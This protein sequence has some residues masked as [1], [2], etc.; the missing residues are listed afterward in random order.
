MDDP[1]AALFRAKYDSLRSTFEARLASLA[2]TIRLAIE[3]TQQDQ[4]LLQLNASE[5]T[6][7]FAPAHA[8]ALIKQYLATERDTFSRGLAVRLA[9]AE[10]EL[11][12]CSRRNE[13]LKSVVAVLKGEAARGERSRSEAIAVD[14]DIQELRREYQIAL[15]DSSAECRQLQTELSHAKRRSGVLKGERDEQAAQ[16][17]SL[18][19]ALADAGAKELEVTRLNDEL[20]EEKSGGVRLSSELAQAQQRLDALTSSHQ[21][22]KLDGR[23]PPPV[24]A[25]TQC[26]QKDLSQRDKRLQL[27]DANR[28]K[29]EA[30]FREAV[31]RMESLM[32]GEA[33]DSAAAI[34]NLRDK[35][36][37]AKE[38]LSTEVERLRG[39]NGHLTKGIAVAEARGSELELRLQA[40]L[41]SKE[42]DASAADAR[43]EA[44][45][46]TAEQARTRADTMSQSLAEAIRE[47]SGLMTETANAKVAAEV[48]EAKSRAA[49]VE[50]ARAAERETARAQAAANERAPSAINLP[51]PGWEVDNMLAEK[52]QEASTHISELR[53]VLRQEVRRREAAE[54]EVSEAQGYLKSSRQELGE[55]RHLA[56]KLEQM[57]RNRHEPWRCDDATL[58]TYEK[59]PRGFGRK[60]CNNNQ[61]ARDLEDE[62]HAR[63]V[64]GAVGEVE[65]EGG[66]GDLHEQERETGRSLPSGRGSKGRSEGG[67]KEEPGLPCARRRSVPQALSSWKGG[68]RL[69]LAALSGLRAELRCVNTQLGKAKAENEEFVRHCAERVAVRVER[70]ERAVRQAGR[71]QAEAQRQA[72]EAE[73]A[74]ATDKKSA[75]TL[76]RVV[77]G[78]SAILL[79]SLG[80]TMPTCLDGGEEGGERHQ[81]MLERGL[82]DLTAGITEALSKVKEGAKKA[83]PA[84]PQGDSVAMVDD[85][86]RR[87]TLDGMVW[88]E[89]SKDDFN[90][91][92]QLQK[93]EAESEL[94][95]LQA[96]LDDMTEKYSRAIADQETVDSGPLREE[97]ERA[98]QEL[99]R[100]ARAHSGVV[101]ALEATLAAEKSHCQDLRLKLERQTRE[102][103]V[104]LADVD[105]RLLQTQQELDEAQQALEQAQ[106]ALERESARR[107]R[108]DRKYSELEDRGLVSPRS[109]SPRSV[110]P[111]PVTPRPVT[112]RVWRPE[113]TTRKFSG[114]SERSQ[115]AQ[116]TLPRPS[117]VRLVLEEARA[118]LGQEES[119]D[120]LAATGVRARQETPADRQKSVLDSRGLT[121]EL[122]SSRRD[123]DGA[124]KSASPSVS[125]L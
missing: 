32:E 88:G 9:E 23:I 78:I 94:Q 107:A 48:L 84:Q 35:A 7:E 89:R 34:K 57:G 80:V 70:L 100:A 56:W 106:F 51:G 116:P 10:A 112:P 71:K 16:S 31:T 68:Q 38:R 61:A 87:S 102:H 73:A 97:R 6:R 17:R 13:E 33:K 86:H 53:T 83:L 49:E 36:L 117:S 20:R 60:S 40:A 37:L 114:E 103:Q 85:R 105:Q 11:L 104:A 110:S 69:F 124:D 45:R 24:C 113:A 50:M 115:L 79:D 5:N 93:I 22:L 46:A 54:A 59:E 18:Q 119:D 120:A 99:A 125:A 101:S 66:R 72:S 27:A 26:L 8:Q 76:R 62:L 82:E 47:Q 4:V 3:S 67:G 64:P 108:L 91:L 28:R 21:E 96:R 81:E 43:E 65:G 118:K 122:D 42:T 74:G 52:L 30:R 29:S 14:A 121:P 109:V 19:Q 39:E 92:A 63:G 98:K 75:D 111:R 25:Q 41:K 58:E 12:R 44:L 123:G 2:D 1:S 15:E 95:S 55:L 90:M 77:K